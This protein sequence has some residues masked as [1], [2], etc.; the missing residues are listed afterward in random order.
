MWFVLLIGC[1]AEPA[2]TPEPEPA[3]VPKPQPEPEP[4][5]GGKT[6]KGK[7]K[8]KGR[9]H[10]GGSDTA[11]SVGA[12]VSTKDDD[13]TRVP[14]LAQPRA[15][16]QVLAHYPAH[17][18]FLHLQVVEARDGFLR[19]V[20]AEHRIEPEKGPKGL[21][22]TE[23]WIDGRHVS[24]YPE[25]CTISPGPGQSEP[26]LYAE[27]SLRSDHTTPK[28]WNPRWMVGCDSGWA[29]LSVDGS[30]GWLHPEHQCDNA[31]TNCINM[32]DE[33]GRR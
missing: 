29:Q 33:L 13:L 23:G 9:G 25:A 27:P 12:Y 1:S 32:C 3:P 8:G 11:C 31:Q 5:R 6:S 21:K 4:A 16:A 2:A 24:L 10:P 7:G 18:L 26:V 14:I 22:V 17:S 19:F 20:A 15:E 30:I 28:E